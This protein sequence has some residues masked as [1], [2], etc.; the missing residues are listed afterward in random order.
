MQ[1][2]DFKE[3]LLSLSIEI[4][5][6]IYNATQKNE[7]DVNKLVN[8]LY[9]IIYYAEQYFIEQE[10]KNQNN[11]SVKER[12]KKERQEVIDK[13]KTFAQVVNSYKRNLFE[14]SKFLENWENKLNHSN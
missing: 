9:R 10:I 14:I 1:N 4:K 11:P 12:L 5:T 13:L 3:K 7:A 6:L 8:I 2:L